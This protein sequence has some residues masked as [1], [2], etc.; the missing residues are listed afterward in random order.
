MKTL[1]TCTLAALLLTTPA[2]AQNTLKSN[3]PDSPVQV[4]SG[5]FKSK[6]RREKVVTCGAEYCYCDSTQGF[7]CTTMVLASC[8]ANALEDVGDD[9]KRCRKSGH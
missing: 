9:V 7:E 8:G 3:E 2:I 5:S 4:Q 6:T 1:I